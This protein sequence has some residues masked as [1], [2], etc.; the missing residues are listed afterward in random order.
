MNKEILE[1]G[2][3]RLTIETLAAAA[4]RQIQVQLCRS[5]EF[6]SKIREGAALLDLMLTQHGGI[7][8]VTTGYGD[9]CTETIKAEQYRELTINLTRFHGCGMGDYF[10][11]E[12]VRALMIVRL[13]T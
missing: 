4:K 3:D 8:G 13:N 12:T 5:A 10:D 2:R 1:I 9:S 6:E 11:D 7:Y